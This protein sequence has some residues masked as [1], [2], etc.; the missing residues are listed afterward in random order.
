MI[1]VG[2]VATAWAQEAAPV[3]SPPVESAPVESVPVDSVPVESPPVESPPVVAPAPAPVVTR[4]LP[5][6]SLVDEGEA[7]SVRD[8]AGRRY[9][10]V[11]FAR[12]VD[13]RDMLRRLED[14]EGMARVG[15]AG[16]AIAGGGSLLAG[17]IV[18]FS[19]SGAPS[20]FDYSVDPTDYET[21][22]DYDAARAFEREQYDKA[23]DAWEAQKLGSAAFLLGVGGV[24]LAT[25]PFVGRDAFEAAERPSRAYSRADAEAIVTRFNAPPPPPPPS[26]ELLV[27]PGILAARGAF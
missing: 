11:Q 23:V 19:N 3:E 15:Q 17:V 22:E 1:L 20:I 10:T 4:T 6:L 8:E 7:W 18:A 5:L 26:V 24:F 12:L 21:A 9:N 14:R 2:L 13:D 25:A 27:G 16:I